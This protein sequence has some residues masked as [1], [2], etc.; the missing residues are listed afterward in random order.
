MHKLIETL[1]TRQRA[2]FIGTLALVVCLALTGCIT[3]EQNPVQ[4]IGL[5]G[6]QT[7]GGDWTA[8]VTITF[9]S[10]PPAYVVTSLEQAGA[11]GSGLVYRIPQAK[12]AD[13]SQ[14]RA[15]A[16]ALTVPGTI[17]TNATP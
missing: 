13:A 1:S 16:T 8:G 3:P 12:A 17:V 2:Q 5:T 14:Q 11:I 10:T 7:A 9:K 15:I 4:S 6:G